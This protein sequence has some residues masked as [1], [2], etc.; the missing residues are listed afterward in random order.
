MFLLIPPGRPSTLPHV[1]WFAAEALTVIAADVKAP[2]GSREDDPRF[3][4]MGRHLVHVFLQSVL[5]ATPGCAVVPGSD[6]PTHVD[7]GVDGAVDGNG[8]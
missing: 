7:V 8:Q 4:R 6:D 2:R 1:A 5:Q 3:F